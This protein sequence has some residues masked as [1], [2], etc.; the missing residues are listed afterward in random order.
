MRKIWEIDKKRLRFPSTE[1]PKEEK[2]KTRGRSR[3]QLASKASLPKLLKLKLKRIKKLKIGMTTEAQSWRA[4][5]KKERER[6]FK[7]LK[8]NK[9]KK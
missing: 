4:G 1:K 5:K 8:I 7:N 3:A 9:S 2:R 6:E